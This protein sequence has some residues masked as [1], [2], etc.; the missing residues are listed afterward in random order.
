MKFS[1]LLPTLVLLFCLQGLSAQDIHFTLFDMAPLRMNP[2]LT[3]AF[4]GTARVGG[5]YRGQW[6]SVPTG[7][8]ITTPSFYADAPII[9]GFRDKDW[10]GVG[11]SFIADQ[12]GPFNL[13]T[14]IAGISA[15]YHLAVDKKGNSILTL[16]G[17]YNQ[18]GRRANFGLG[19]LISEE[20]IGTNLGGGGIGST[21]SHEFN[22]GSDFEKSYKDINAGLLF[23]TKL[24]KQTNLELGLAALH[25]GTPDA[26]LLQTNDDSNR[27]MTITAH[28]KY[29]RDLAGKWSMA[30]ALFFQT[31]QGGKNEILAQAWAG[32]KMNPDVKLNFGLG[33]RVGDAASVLLG[34]DYKDVRAALSYDINLRQ[35]AANITNNFGG[36]ELA[37]YYIIKVY[38]KPEL[39]PRVL[40]P[41][42]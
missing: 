39:P 35:T 40:C 42:F 14:N 2:A 38:K 10:V 23:R 29:D 3:G 32:Y 4:S 1:R 25:I 6:L 37:A 7:A 11:F 8:D 13:Q 31:T 12:G 18:V 36:F 28:A 9:R 33:W 21:E 41:E 5:I 30:P 24:D 22:T 15:S 16:G 26:A 19:E 27:N 20:T 17:Q 34:A